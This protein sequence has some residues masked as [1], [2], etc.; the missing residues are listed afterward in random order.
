MKKWTTVEQALTPG[1]QTISLHE[2]DGSYTIRLDGVELMSTRRHASEERLAELACAHMKGI[3]RARILI[4]GL[5]FGYTLRAALTAVPGDASVVV[6]EILPAV[7]NW[8]RNPAYPLAADAMADPRVTILQRDVAEVIRESPAGFDSIILDVDN[9]PVSLTSGDND[10]LYS[11]SGLGV[12]RAALRPRGCVAYWSAA[13]DPGFERLMR[14][15]GFA[16]DVQRC[17][18]HGNSGISHTLFVGR[19]IA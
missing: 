11:Y 15:A 17:R 18:A 10:Q 13:P 7:I 8:N 12:A 1:G 4:G 6:A 16:V 5:G 3:S 19:L 14:R 9:G 2:H